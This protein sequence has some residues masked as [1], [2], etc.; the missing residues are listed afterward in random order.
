MFSTSLLVLAVM[1]LTWAKPS[2][3]R[4]MKTRIEEHLGKDRNSQILKH[5]QEN[6]HCKQVR[7]FG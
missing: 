6:P 4:H 5:L 7:N 1:L 2:A 3:T